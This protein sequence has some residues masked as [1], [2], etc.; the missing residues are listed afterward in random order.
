MFLTASSIQVRRKDRT[1][2]DIPHLELDDR[3]TLLLGANGAGKSTLFRV[4]TGRLS[5]TS[6]EVEGDGRITM[7][8]QLFQPI[9]GFTSAEYC[10]YVAWLNGQRRATA[11]AEAARW[12]DFVGLTAVATQRCESLSGG[13][14]ARL[15]IATALN[16]GTARLFLDEPS[17]ALDPLNKELVSDI[18]QNIAESGSALTV[19][20]H[21]A[22]ELQSP[23]TRV[24]VLHK[25]QLHFDGTP[26]EF[27][28]LGVNSP[29]NNP[30]QD[31][32]AA[33]ARSFARRQGRI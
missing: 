25:G 32:A 4:L 3:P 16:S 17:A 10:A 11:R 33:L 23:F 6:G 9:I 27:L 7:V 30:G 12:L 19:S 29:K 24:L 31:P 21:D 1:I 5:P 18:Y 26:E 28:R 20:T 22:G 2:L 8:E 14:K 15:A 13:E